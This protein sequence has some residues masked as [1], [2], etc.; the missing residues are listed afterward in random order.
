MPPHVYLKEGDCVRIVRGPLTGVEG[1]LL[2][3]GAK[4]QLIISVNIIQRSVAVVVAEQDVEPIGTNP[5]SKA[6]EA[7]SA[8]VTA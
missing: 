4:N 7:A 5:R 8:L 3:S 2:R 6:D 1:S